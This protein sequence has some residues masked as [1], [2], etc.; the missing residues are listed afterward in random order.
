MAG[1]KVFQAQSVPQALSP[2]THQLNTYGTACAEDYLPAAESRPSLTKTVQGGDTALVHAECTGTRTILNKDGAVK[3]SDSEGTVPQAT[4]LTNHTFTSN[5]RFGPVL[6]AFIALASVSTAIAQAGQLDKTFGSGGM[7][8]AQS[9]G[10]SNTQATA[11]AIRATARL[12]SSDKR[13]RK[14]MVRSRPCYGLL[15]AAIWIPLSVLGE[16]QLWTLV[17]EAASSPQGNSSKATA[18]LLSEFRLVVRMVPP[19]W[20][21]PGLTRTA[22]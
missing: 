17:Q 4:N 16:C 22:A 10:L 13:F 8:L 20:N 15:P 18:R 12:W 7:L 2:Y 3:F 19:Y 5:K 6:V 21:W 9:V 1:L 11:I 14:R